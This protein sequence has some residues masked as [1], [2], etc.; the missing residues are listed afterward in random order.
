M[1]AFTFNPNHILTEMIGEF[2]YGQI[3]ARRHHAP[4][5][6]SAGNKRPSSKTRL[7]L[8]YKQGT[9]SLLFE[10]LAAAI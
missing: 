7:R 5:V 3:P 2:D 4:I 9:P 10:S 8:L 1:T 6:A